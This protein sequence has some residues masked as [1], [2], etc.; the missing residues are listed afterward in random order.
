MRTLSAFT[1]A[2]P[3][4]DRQTWGP[5]AGWARALV[6]ALLVGA[7]WLGVYFR[8]PLV[9]NAE[10]LFG[11]IFTMLALQLL[12]VRLGVLA[13]ALIA[14]ATLL[15]WPHPYAAII[16]TA[17]VA[18][19]A[20]LTQRFKMGLVLADALAWLLVCMPVTYL[21]Y[22]LLLNTSPEGAS[23]VMTKQAV[24][25]IANALLARLLYTWL[26][27]RRSDYK[28]AY[29]EM[30]YNLMAV[31]VL[32]PTLLLLALSSRADFA[33]LDQT[34]RRGLQQKVGMVDY[35]VN[36]WVQ[37]RIRVVQHLAEL[38]Q[39][40]PVEQMQAR[41]EQALA[42]DGNFLRFGLRDTASMVLTYAPKL[43]QAGEVNIGK[44]FA[45]RP[46]V[47]QLRRTL[48]PMLP[49]VVTAR[50]DQP[51][52]VATV[53]APVIHQGRFAGY[54]SGVLQLDAIRSHLDDLAADTSLLYTVLDRQ[55]QVILSNRP[56]QQMM[57]PFDRGAGT[58]ATTQGDASLWTAAPAAKSLVLDRWGDSFYVTQTPVGEVAGWQIILEQAVAPFQRSLHQ[59]YARKLFLLLAIFL[60]GSLVSEWVSRK[61][62]MTLNQLSMLTHDLPERLN[63]G[64]GAIAWPHSPVQQTSAL[65]DNFRNMS[66]LVRA[67]FDQIRAANALLE[68]RV[69]ERTRALASHA[70]KHQALIDNSHDIIF[71]LDANGILTFVSVAWTTLLG[72]PLAQ[73]VGHALWPRVHPDDLAGCQAALRSVFDDGQARHDIDFRVCHQDASWHWL[74]TNAMPLRDEQQ[75]VVGIEGVAKDVSA[76]RVLEIKIN[77]FAFF[78][79]LTGLPNRRLLTDRL[80]QT[81][82][83]SK[84]SGLFGALMFLDLDNFK[85]LNDAHGHE[86]GDM[87]LV[88]V[89][90]RLQ[91]CVREVDTVARVGGDE[92]VVVLGELATE[93]AHSVEQALA[94]A[95]KIRLKLAEPYLLNTTDS[96]GK[97]LQVTHRCAASIGLVVFSNHE[98]SQA[99]LMK[100]ADA[101]MYQAKAAGRNRIQ[102][103]G[104]AGCVGEQNLVITSNK[105]QAV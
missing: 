46:Y 20:W 41:L 60:I 81:M 78:D 15:V 38:T 52:P 61:T 18:L 4:P 92:F 85:P 104:G 31:A 93:Q 36:D 86:L 44:Q 63:D 82:V 71:T 22:P 3:V 42:S 79:T 12:G 99:E 67:Q 57:Q 23:V 49:E 30:L 80:A 96:L 29:R 95:E 11:S 70:A 8:Y 101:A 77:H 103:Y 35:Q 24:S 26:A 34:L 68:Q 47:A 13:G 5:R 17:E 14:C 19:V 62:S 89:A 105:V 88:E 25:G 98:I 1:A 48:K 16:M 32:F 75:R 45:E 90:H 9:L 7:G 94:V 43:D 64:A 56:D 76:H 50:I 40:L 51:D 28:V 102:L 6:F 54:I 73:I 59:I 72:H 65:I 66:A 21:A 69:T 55:G 37:D 91:G 2:A 83:A 100:Q 33:Q 74:S 10:F 53:L 27:T 58:F 39:R 97:L 84:R 87:L